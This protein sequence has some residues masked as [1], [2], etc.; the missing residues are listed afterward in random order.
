MI[1][2]ISMTELTW[3]DMNETVR[4]RACVIRTLSDTFNVIVWRLVKMNLNGAMSGKLGGGR[5][6][7]L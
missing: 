3:M 6:M 7:G 4:I 2:M 5:C 1:H